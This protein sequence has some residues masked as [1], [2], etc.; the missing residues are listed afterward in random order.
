MNPVD[1]L[2]FESPADKSKALH[3]T[4]T[5]DDNFR[6]CRFSPFKE[7]ASWPGLVIKA[8]R[9]SKIEGSLSTLRDSFRLCDWSLLR[10]GWRLD[11]LG[12]PRAFSTPCKFKSQGNRSVST[13]GD[14]GNVCV[15]GDSNQ[16]NWWTKV[17]VPV[18]DERG[19]VTGSNSVFIEGG[20]IEMDISKSLFSF[21]EVGDAV[22]PSNLP[23]FSNILE[24]DRRSPRPKN[25][26]G[27]PWKYSVPDMLRSGRTDGVVS[28]VLDFD[29]NPWTACTKEERTVQ[30]QT[31]LF[32][33]G[34]HN[35]GTSSVE[36]AKA[37]H[38]LVEKF[39]K[40]SMPSHRDRCLVFV[41]T[42]DMLHERIQDVD[43]GKFGNQVQSQFC[44]KF[45]SAVIT[46][47]QRI[48]MP[49]HFRISRLTFAIASASTLPTARCATLSQRSRPTTRARALGGKS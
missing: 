10:G 27:W 6:G 47:T 12:L 13:G 44:L 28:A 1:F 49:L 3:W 5:T 7:V 15:I 30:P 43:K 29:R 17:Y 26:K 37:V 24:K 25:I 48:C 38:L 4:S 45:L 22:I 11:E 14:L 35:C 46:A 36:A 18:A 39:I 40:W 20:G 42:P 32:H 33:A 8:I 34:S 41:S 21:E 23:Y 9:S 19:M 2:I 31:I 16:K